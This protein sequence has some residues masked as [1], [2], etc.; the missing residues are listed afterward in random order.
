MICEKLNCTLDS[1]G[2]GSRND[3][4]MIKIYSSLEENI[5]NF[6]TNGIYRNK[7]GNKKILS[8]LDHHYIKLIFLVPKLA[9]SEFSVPNIFGPLFNAALFI[10]SFFCLAIPY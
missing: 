6:I 10:L 3:N 2:V 7:Y 1:I 8:G 9:V 4:T 5:Y